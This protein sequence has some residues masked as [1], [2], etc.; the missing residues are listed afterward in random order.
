MQEREQE[1]AR[2]TPVHPSYDLLHA[3]AAALGAEGEPQDNAAIDT[4]WGRILMGH[5]FADPAALATELCQ[6]SPGRRDIAV[7]VDK[8]HVVLSYAPQQLFLDPS[9]TLRLQLDSPTSEVEPRPD[10]DVHRVRDEAEA[11]AINEI[12]L[13]RN[14]VPTDTGFVWRQRN[15]ETLIY[16][17]ATDPG[18]GTVLGTV[19]GVDHRRLFNDPGDGSSLWCLAV[20]PQAARPGVGET[21]VRSLA[22]HFRGNGRR[23][24]DLSVMHNNQE[25][26]AL[27]DKL[28]FEPVLTFA[29]KNKNAYNESLFIGPELESNLNPYARIIVDEARARGIS[30]EVLDAEEGYFRLSRGGKSITCR[31]SLSELTSSVAMSRCQDK[32][33]TSR[34]L[35]RAGIRVPAF[36]LAGE[37]AA[38]LA[39]LKKQGRIVVKPTTGEQGK[40]ITV[41]VDGEAALESALAKAR[42]FGDRVLLEAYH[43][44]D[45]LRVVVIN[46]EV[47]AAAVRQP[48]QIVGD[49]SHDARTLIEKQS[50]RRQAATGGESHIPID[51]ET[52]RCLGERGYSLDS[53]IDAGVTVPVRKTANLHTGGT[54][55]DVTDV[56]HPRLVETAVKAARH[57]E[58]PVVGFDF[59]I[60][61]PDQ[62][63]HV[64]IEA[65]E[66]VGLAN[67]EPQPTAQ[68]FLDLLFPLSRSA[69]RS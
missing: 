57:L 31:E 24:M 37:H 43:P 28:G 38:N 22:A 3:E 69:R 42:Q 62:P 68:R 54:I 29:V 58:I 19:T 53:I 40:G 18:S 55:H 59:M 9:D 36:Q 67:H 5:T 13:K 56:L 25:A 47:V 65:N 23:Y 64:L 17:V 41:G 15:S 10:L 35:T 51:D 1:M 48:A 20:D 39:F 66:R 60:T 63:E 27:Y 26:K 8:P 2:L 21:L 46:Y 16:L 6:E 61:A 12:Y 7:Y 44:G 49:G 45:D 34:W 33:V 11:Q 52:K 50:R 32:Y 30:V 14:M 4:G